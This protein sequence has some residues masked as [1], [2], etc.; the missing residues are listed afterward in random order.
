MDRDAGIKTHTLEERIGTPL[1]SRLY[2]MCKLVEISGGDF[3][4]NQ[5]KDMPL[6]RDPVFDE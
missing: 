5:K 1:R 6:M 3:R 2:E 4:K